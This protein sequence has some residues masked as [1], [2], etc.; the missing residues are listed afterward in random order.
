MRSAVENMAVM[1]SEKH[2]RLNMKR[3]VHR[4]L[5]ILWVFYALWVL[6]WPIGFDIQNRNRQMTLAARFYEA[7]SETS[8]PN[9]GEEYAKRVKQA[10]EIK[11]G[12]SYTELRWNLLWCIPLAL[13]G[14]PLVVY[15]IVYG[16]I[17][18][19]RKTARWVGEGFAG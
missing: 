8:N 17:L 11:I 4:V 7:C 16:S 10:E 9:C 2:R 6:W 3:G 15:G 18:G 12:S 14:P 1:G 13:F 5:I 19:V